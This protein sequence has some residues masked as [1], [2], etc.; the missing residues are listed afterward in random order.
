[1]QKDGRGNICPVTI[2]LPTLAMQAKQKTIDEIGEANVPD[3]EKVDFNRICVENFMELLDK[4]LAE[5]HE[6]S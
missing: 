3:I 5:A 2:I 1:M 6:E 4:K